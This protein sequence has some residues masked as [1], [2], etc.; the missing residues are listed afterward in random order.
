MEG[1]TNGI[2]PSSIYNSNK[3]K[4]PQQGFPST[5]GNDSAMG[6]GGSGE[7]RQD[8]LSLD[9]NDHDDAPQPPPTPAIQYYFP[10]SSGK[11]KDTKP[12]QSSLP[13]ASVPPRPNI[14]SEKQPHPYHFYH[15]PHPPHQQQQNLH[16]IESMKANFL[17]VGRP[18]PPHND[19]SRPS[20]YDPSGKPPSPH[21]TDEVSPISPAGWIGPDHEPML[22]PAPDP[23]AAKARQ[24]HLDWLRQINAMAHQANNSTTHGANMNAPTSHY[25]MLDGAGSTDKNDSGNSISAVDPEM[26]TVSHPIPSG[27]VIP[28]PR[29]QQHPTHQQ[30][31][32][33]PPSQRHPTLPQTTIPPI[34]E[35]AS[36][37]ATTTLVPPHSA[38]VFPPPGVPLH[39]T[40]AAALAAGNP[41]FFSHAAAYLRQQASSPVE[42]EE[43]RAKRLERNRESAR[44]SR[45]RKKER[46]S[47]LG[48]QVSKL[49]SKVEKERR[50]QMGAM[51]DVMMEYERTTIVRLKDEYE[52]RGGDCNA[53]ADE[54]LAVALEQFIDRM[55]D[56]IRKDVVEF[57]CTALG[58]Y[59]LPRY[60]KFL[61]WLTLHP[62]SYFMVGKDEHAKR[63]STE[64]SRTVRA[65][66]G[67]ISSKQ[68]GDELTNG[69]KLE[70]GTIIP[71]S[72]SS[73]STA[74]HM[75]QLDQGIEGGERAGMMAQAFD[76]G[77]MWPLIC[78]ELSIS[79]DQEDKF[80]QSHKR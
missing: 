26:P 15:Q 60:Q 4:R 70:D 42:S 54:W 16:R 29:Y 43:K 62:E 63:E 5:Y 24:S 37:A 7:S 13:A 32:L 31:Q 36:A 79:V 78:F 8:R 71:P 77:R 22:F 56:P 47:T 41:L 51:D 14:Q 2:R 39:P 35:V 9:E 19:P 61:L 25:N 40:A 65:A 76:A 23:L 80:L 18:R 17:G 74:S 73:S 53:M 44:K 10:S 38:V 66:P 12:P 64:T 6:G 59:L 28:P 67:K 49:L 75:E 48:E 21:G 30:P 1:T 69:R 34:P 72:L 46:L 45:R 11:Q 3:N 20:E 27:S 68:I 58:Q 55:G 52:E 57:Q 50:I 33:A